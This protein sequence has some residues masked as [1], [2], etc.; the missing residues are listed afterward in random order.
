M[1]LFQLIILPLLLGLLGF[2][3]PCSLSVNAIFLKYVQPLSKAARIQQGLIF[4][5]V[6]AVVLGIIGLLAAF[7]GKSVF[8]FEQTYFVIFGIFI[9]LLGVY[10]LTKKHLPFSF[11]TLRFSALVPKKKSAAL[12][13]LVFGLV[14]PACA[15][16]LVLVL[17]GTT[18]GTGDLFTGFIS[19]FL[20]GVA[21]SLPLLFLVFSE[22]SMGYV[23]KIIA[24]MHAVPYVIGVVLIVLGVVTALS[25]VWWIQ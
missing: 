11:P 9:A 19:L 12:L 13:G 20:F 1:A 5:V 8:A 18:L 24:K 23:K 3:E 22:K 14:I 2:F 21:L 6:R 17:V 15:L 10:E 16:P 25:S 4:L 7:V